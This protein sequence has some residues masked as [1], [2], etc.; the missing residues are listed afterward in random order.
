MFIWLIDMFHKIHVHIKFFLKLHN[1]IRQKYFKNKIFF[2]YNFKL[3]FIDIQYY[4]QIY[5]G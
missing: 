3:L 5:S 1:L 2:Y 4:S